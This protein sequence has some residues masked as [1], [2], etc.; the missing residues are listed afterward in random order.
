MTGP[1]P[2][3]LVV[4]D[5]A[6]IQAFLRATLV[7]HGYRCTAVGTARE[8]LMQVT[9]QPPDV[10]LLDLGLPDGDGLGVAR[11]IREWSTVPV[12]VISARG[13]ERDKVAALDMGA[14][15]YLTKPFGVPEMLARIR[16]ALRHAARKDATPPAVQTWG[17]GGPEGF[18][19]DLPR[20]LVFRRRA[21][22]EGEVRLTPTEFRLLAMFVRHNGKVLTHA[23]ILKEVW[24]PVHAGEVAYL[25]VYV[26]QLRQKLEA[27]P[28]LPRWLLTEPGVGYRLVESDAE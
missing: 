20:R 19:V 4:E 17:G 7:A 2:H 16:V 25:R 5:E 12:I 11:Q 8:A 28:S 18:R 26:G 22:V 27:V 14:D 9:A 6:P 10:V 13:Q 24:G 21:G 1:A 3:I 23:E 15:D